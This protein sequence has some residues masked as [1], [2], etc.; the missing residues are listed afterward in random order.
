MNGEQQTTNRLNETPNS[1]LTSK[2][3]TILSNNWGNAILAVVIYFAVSIVGQFIP[4]I[5]GLIAIVITG[6]LMAGFALYFLNMSRKK[7]VDVKQLFDGFNNFGNA[8]VAYLLY[9][10]AVF[11]VLLPIIIFAV[12]SVFGV[13]GFGFF[14]NFDPENLF[15]TFSEVNILLILLLVL[16]YFSLLIPALIV[17][18]MLSQIFFILADKPETS[19]LNAVKESYH[20]MKGYK[21]KYF[22]LMLRF[23]GWGILSVFTCF[24]GLLFLVP[25]MQTSFALFY[26]DLKGD[27]TDEIDQIGVLTENID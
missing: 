25:Y 11:V 22:T 3:Y 10:V 17:Q 1:Q 6:P 14:A 26:D 18:I 24:I 16:L 27:E 4:I 8:L 7:E 5:G 20:M 23:I 12:V 19:G 13:L 9:L 21:W 15:S 2:A